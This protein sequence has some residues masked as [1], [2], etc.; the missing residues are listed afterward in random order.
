M[1]VVRDVDALRWIRRELDDAGTR[2]G[3]LRKYCSIGDWWEMDEEPL[4]WIAVTR[5]S[6]L[7]MG[8]LWWIWMDKRDDLEQQLENDHS[9]ERCLR[10]QDQRP[11][12]HCSDGSVWGG[13]HGLFQALVEV[14]SRWRYERTAHKIKA[15]AR[16]KMTVKY[17]PNYRKQY[18]ALTRNRKGVRATG[19]RSADNI[20][21]ELQPHY[22]RPWLFSIFVREE[23]S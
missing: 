17:P 9:R 14:G 8:R 5:H 19:Y 10:G 11:M 12:Y 4:R 20:P 21:M 23:A 3:R 15:E 2:R 6:L 18:I 1:N 7:M 22:C 13:S 16:A